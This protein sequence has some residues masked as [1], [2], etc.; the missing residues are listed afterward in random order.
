MEKK[1]GN[2]SNKNNTKRY[3]L[4]GLGVVAVAAA[5][6]IIY[7]ATKPKKKP[8]LL[9]NQGAFEPESV[10]TSPSGPSGSSSDSS[11]SGSRSGFPLSKGSRGELVKNLQEALIKSYGASIL[12]RYG[13]DGDWGSET[14]NALIS[15]GLP[16]VITAET[17][18]KLVGDS[19]KSSSGSS[20]STP[21]K[22]K[23][24]P[25]LLA[26]LLHNAILGDNFIEALRLL[27]KI[28]TASGYV[29]VNGYFKEKRIG[30]VR[31]TLVN[32]LLSQFN[33]SAEKKKLN[34]H[35]YRM[36]LK[37]NGYQWSLSGIG[38]ILYD[39]IRSLQPTMVWNAKGQRMKVPRNTILGELLEARNGVTKF[40]TLDDKILYTN[41][42]T[43]GYV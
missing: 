33:S 1:Q 6:T 25:A 18:I 39:Q 3:V 8:G 11:S 26:S 24:K 30:G 28:F 31:K 7:F 19:G 36:G 27:S 41:T 32:A 10:A 29:K 43:I 9:D 38:Q 42:N 34:T 22:K 23:F 5:G 20:T 13:A 37:Y 2:M 15:K 17:F 14:E 21:T 4:I 16:T 35:F 40:K 12:P